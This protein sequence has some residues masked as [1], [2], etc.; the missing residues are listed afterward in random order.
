MV[1]SKFVRRPPKGV[2]HLFQGQICALRKDIRTVP[3]WLS[4][5]RPKMLVIFRRFFKEY[6]LIR[7]LWKSIRTVPLVFFEE[8]LDDDD[9][10]LLSAK[11]SVEVEFTDDFANVS[12]F[13]DPGW[14]N[15]SELPLPSQ[16]ETKSVTRRKRLAVAVAAWMMVLGIATGGVFVLNKSKVISISNIKTTVSQFIATGELSFVQNESLAAQVAGNGDK[17]IADNTFNNEL[18]PVIEAAPVV[19]AAPVIKTSAPT[20]GTAKIESTNAEIS[21]N[22]SQLADAQL[23]DAQLAG[24]LKKAE[25]VSATAQADPTQAL[26]D[27]S[28]DLPIEKNNNETT[29]ILPT[30]WPAEYANAN[31]L[32]DPN[33]VVVDI[34]GGLVKKEGWL[35]LSEHPMIRSVKA[36]QRENGAR[37]VIYINGA[38]PR[39]MTA[40]KTGG[41]AIRLYRGDTELTGQTQQ[42][43]MLNQ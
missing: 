42:V 20:Q 31:R 8:V 41:I 35:E 36:V 7:L 25:L 32:R 28:Q 21:P 22:I 11:D 13:D 5:L 19:E 16:M 18:A 1:K 34:P 26:S 9:H 29:L 39:F 30:R 33:G 10:E 17:L 3:L 2:W 24:Q 43:A 40:P 4:L 27:K 15:C 12:D 6:A 14:A 37:F 38:L 23:A